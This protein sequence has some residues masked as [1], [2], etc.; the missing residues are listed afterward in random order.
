MT[1]DTGHFD[2]LMTVQRRETSRD[3]MG[4][5]N[6]EWLS[7]GQCW[8]R[9]ADQGGRELYRAQQV[10]GEVTAVVYLREQFAGLKP[11]DRL[12]VDDDNGNARTFN[13]SA[14]S[15]ASDRAASHGQTVAVTENV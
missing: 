12:R 5:P 13:I 1:M 14:I 2:N 9:I 15:G 10:D 6:S 7:I 11:S 4:N 8:T 3:A